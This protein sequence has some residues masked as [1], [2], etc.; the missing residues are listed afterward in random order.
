[1]TPN[2]MLYL[3]GYSFWLDFPF[4]IYEIYKCSNSA[5][6]DSLVNKH[7]NVARN[8]VFTNIVQISPKWIN[9]LSV[10][11]LFSSMSSIM[12]SNH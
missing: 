6:M 7:I 1:M 3:H 4:K 9:N 12:E 2:A 10:T 11:H 5:A 8:R